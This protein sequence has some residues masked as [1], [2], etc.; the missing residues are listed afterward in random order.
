MEILWAH[1]G[2][3]GCIVLEYTNDL[4]IHW[5]TSIHLA[6]GDH[7]I[8]QERTTSMFITSIVTVVEAITFN[9]VKGIGMTLAIVTFVFIRIT[10]CVK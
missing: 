4:A 1:T 10:N 2:A 3:I 8:T 9:I 7:N 6:D 5:A